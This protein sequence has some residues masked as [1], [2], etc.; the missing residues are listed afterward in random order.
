LAR[1]ARILVVAD[2]AAARRV[3]GIL[4]S[5]DMT[6]ES[7]R[8][9]HAA[10]SAIDGD[11]PDLLILDADLPGADASGAVRRLRADTRTRHLPVVLLTSVSEDHSPVEALAMGASDYVVR[12]FSARELGARVSTQLRLAER[13]R[14]EDEPQVSAADR[15]RLLAAA[16]EARA[17]AEAANRTKDEFL[18]TL[19]HELRTPLN[20][21]AGW[22]HLLRAGR[23]DDATARRALETIDRNARIQ[24]QLVADMLD[25]S[26]IVT[27]TLEVQMRPVAPAAILEAAL[28]T[29]QV[30]AEAKSIRV[31]L[32]VDPLTGPVLGD[33]DRLRQLVWNLLANA[34]KF[35]PPGGRVDV[36]LWREG[37][38]AVLR[39]TDDGV[40]IARD[41]LPFVFEPF[42]QSDPSST[43]SHGGLGLG[44]AIVRHLAQAHG[45]TVGA[46]SAGLGLGAAFTLRLPLDG[47]SAATARPAEPAAALPPSRGPS[48]QGVSVLVVDAEPA[49]RERTA[50][51]L[52]ERGAGVLQA[53]GL[54]EALELVK[55]LRPHVLLARVGRGE[56]E[57][58]RLIRAVREI[59]PERG[60]LTPAAVLS[61]EAAADERLRSLLAGYQVH[62]A[63]PVAAHELATVTANLAGRT[64]DFL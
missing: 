12:P 60:G 35:T 15:N 19:S 57:G 8:D 61:D 43:R 34:I 5:R 25:V 33:A 45:G 58:Y 29:V 42:R 52:R 47:V 28:E 36:A 1:R 41:F 7:A 32:A 40:G 64:R 38:E 10:L 56:E 9:A 55:R 16:E 31:G 21:I 23:L 46:E 26:R 6:V 39:V 18:A 53:S 27:G 3:A 14:P 24:A 30:A 54:E 20:A 22:V 17:Q 48:L 44:L 50:A 63:Q 13:K 37:T 49:G 11:V 59:P 2:G 51:L 62:L 4:S